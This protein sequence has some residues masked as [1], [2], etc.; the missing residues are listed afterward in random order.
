MKWYLPLMIFVSCKLQSQIKTS[1]K[2]LI[3][4]HPISR[5]YLVKRAEH[6]EY[7]SIR[8][9][10][11]QFSNNLDRHLVLLPITSQDHCSFVVYR[12]LIVFPIIS[13]TMLCRHSNSRS[14]LS[15]EGLARKVSI[16]NSIPS[17]FA[18]YN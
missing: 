14:G 11:T 8:Y 13:E 9:I 5:T 12:Y 16:S 1:S 4:F 18:F 17:G 7:S 2:L 15:P 10:M 6:G 3:L